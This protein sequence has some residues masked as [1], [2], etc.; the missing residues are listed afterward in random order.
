[1]SYCPQFTATIHPH[2][3]RAAFIARHIADA[4][5]LLQQDRQHPASLIRCAC[6]VLLCWS[7]DSGDRQVARAA[8]RGIGVIA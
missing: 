6:Q 2:P 3:R 8:L 5:T 4:R 7:D 1:M